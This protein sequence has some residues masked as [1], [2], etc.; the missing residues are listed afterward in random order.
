M[1]QNEVCVIP[2]LVLG[3]FNSVLLEE[4]RIGGNQIT[5][6]EVVEFRYCVDTCGL[7]EL[8]NQGHK[9]TWNDKHSDQG[10]FS[11]IDWAFINDKWLD[12]MPTCQAKFLPEGIS[13]HCPIQLILENDRV[14]KKKSFLFCN[15]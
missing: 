12:L 13:D 3:D 4:D 10:V 2:W 15:V 14:R 6:A 8:P 9:Y 1:Q 11:K 7:I 5:W